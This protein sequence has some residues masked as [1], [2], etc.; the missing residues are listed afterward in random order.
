MVIRLNRHVH[1]VCVEYMTP[2][3]IAY[4]SNVPSDEYGLRSTIDRMINIVSC[5]PGLTVRQQSRRFR[6]PAWPAG[7]GPDFINGALVVDSDLAPVDVLSLLH[8]IEA[9]MGRTR[10]QRWEPRTCDLDL[11]ASG[12]RVLPGPREVTRWM[13]MNDTAAQ[14]EVP[15]GLVLPHPRMHRRGFVL[16]PLCDIAPDWRH[17][18]LDRTVAEMMADL[19]P[20]AI[21]E[22]VEMT[23]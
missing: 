16:V 21:A 8:D 4:G 5:T 19:P 12:N 14:A 15:D 20:E 1:G 9:R 22:V 10:K 7:S 6:T 11:I 17:P 18:V 2:N 13:D 23:S 3:L